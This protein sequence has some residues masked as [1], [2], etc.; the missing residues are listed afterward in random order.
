M[1]GD[2]GHCCHGL[3]AVARPNVVPEL[4]VPLNLVRRDEA[5]WVGRK[6]HHE[7]SVPADGAVVHVQQV[8]QRPD[9]DR[10]VV[11]PLVLVLERRVGLGW[12]VDVAVGIAALT[13]C[14]I[15]AL[16]RRAAEKFHK[17]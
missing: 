4:F 10:S 16:V 2:V 8:A 7:E 1:K 5:V 9:T 17:C 14:F 6:V 15:S 13:E 12:L 11:K 3:P